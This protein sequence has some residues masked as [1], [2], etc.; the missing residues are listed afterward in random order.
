MNIFERVQRILLQPKTEWY[1]IQQEPTY[2]AQLYTGYIMPLAAIGPICTVIGLLLFGSSYFGPLMISIPIVPIIVGAVVQYALTL[3]LVYV[4]ALIINALAP[5]FQGQPQ[6]YQALK[7]Y[8]YS[9]TP[10]WLGGI[11][12]IIPQLAI[13]GIIVAL[14]SLYLLYLGLPV[15]MQ[16]PPDKSIGY[17]VT[18]IIIAIVISIIIGVIVGAITAAMFRASLGL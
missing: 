7:L 10:A 17:I 1:V 5:T 8:A 12:S 18:I 2:P 4:M 9:A 13:L 14:Y 3:A 6:I 15:M 11:F 16:S